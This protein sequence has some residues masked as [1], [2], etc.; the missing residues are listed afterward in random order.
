MSHALTACAKLGAPVEIGGVTWGPHPA[1]VDLSDAQIAE[2]YQ[3]RDR[4]TVHSWPATWQPPRYRVSARAKTG[5][6]VCA[7]GRVFGAIALDFEAD[8]PEL[9]DLWNARDSLSVT[10]PRTWQ[11]PDGSHPGA[12]IARARRTNGPG[13]WRIVACSRDHRTIAAGGHVFARDPV[14]IMAVPATAL[15]LWHARDKLTLRWLDAWIAPDGSE[16]GP[17]DLP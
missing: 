3:H 9:R 15:D 10:W 11:A 7:A 17:G 14:E 16:H 4:L 6:P 1:T 8:D 12:T 2:V 13:P 5:A